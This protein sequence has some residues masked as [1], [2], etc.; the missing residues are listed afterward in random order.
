MLIK[1]LSWKL[2][3]DG[4]GVLGQLMTAVAI[5]CM[6]AGGGITNGL[7]KVL[8]RSPLPSVIGQNWINVAFSITTAVSLGI[9]L[10]IAAFASPLADYLIQPGFTAVLVLLALTQGLVGYAAVVQAELSSRGQSWTY[11]KI[12]IVGTL[13]GTLGLVLAVFIFN[14]RGAAYSIVLMPAATAVVAIGYLLIN[15]KKMLSALRIDFDSGRTKQLAAFSL[16]TM[17]GAVSVPMAQI[18]IRSDFAALEGWHQVGLWQG[19][20]KLSDLY[21]QLVGVFLINY[22]LPK[23]SAA[24]TFRAALDELK[25]TLALVVPVMVC[26]FFVVYWLR[27]WVVQ[28]VFSDAFQPMTDYFVVQML[29]DLLR[30]VAAAISF[31]F[32][33]RGHVRV[34]IIFEL[35]QGLLLMIS[36][37]CWADS[38]GKMAPVYA[39]LTTYLILASGM[40]VGLLFWAKKNP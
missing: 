31:L 36:F 8:A 35:A 24:P 33:A 22:L 14:F 11:A 3:P 29:G 26:V 7:I 21:M 23:Y 25:A 20:I 15:Q 37:T 6:F 12:N 28:L 5:V 9:G 10:L 17:V 39:H 1:L 30:T 4:F 34:A 19:I 2:G 16:V 38:G 40:L 27:F 18:F 32:M 13:L